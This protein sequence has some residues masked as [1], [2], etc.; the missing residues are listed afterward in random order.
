MLGRVF[1]HFVEKS[2]IA[3]MVRRLLERVLGAERLDA[4]YEQTAQK[5]YTR[6][7]LFST[8]YELLSR[9]VL[10]IK[11]S[12]HTAYQEFEEDLGAS[13]VSV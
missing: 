6:T 8:V 9:V 3:V 2:P 13:I 7:L 10:T 5:Q 4:W 12:I 1:Q 11:P